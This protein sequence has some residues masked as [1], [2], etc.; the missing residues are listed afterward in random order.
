MR[1]LSVA[2]SDVAGTGEG[3]QKE[4][5]PKG[6]IPADILLG[7]R[8]KNSM[9]VIVRMGRYRDSYN[10][11]LEQM[12]VSSVKNIKTGSLSRFFCNYCIFKRIY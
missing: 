10:R 1:T 8:V 4:S 6:Y 3:K 7:H 9:T 5:T 2:F 11:T 12:S